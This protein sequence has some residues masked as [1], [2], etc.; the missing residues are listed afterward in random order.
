VKSSY[1]G[2]AAALQPLL[3]F[4]VGN[5]RSSVYFSPQHAYDFDPRY[6]APESRSA[7]R[8]AGYSFT[9][10]SG[11]G[12]DDVSGWLAPTLTAKFDCWALGKVALELVLG[13]GVAAGGLS[14]WEAQGWWSTL[15]AALVQV[16]RA[17]CADDPLQG[18]SVDQA[19]AMAFVKM[20]YP[21]AAADRLR[22]VSSDG[23]E[24]EEKGAGGGDGAGSSKAAMEA[25]STPILAARTAA[26]ASTSEGGDSVSLMSVGG[27]SSCDGAALEPPASAVAR[28][29]APAAAPYC[30]AFAYCLPAFHG[31]RLPEIMPVEP[32]AAPVVRASRMQPSAAGKKVAGVTSGS[33]SGGEKKMKGAKAVQGEEKAQGTKERSFWQRGLHRCCKQGRKFRSVLHEVFTPSSCFG[34]AALPV[35]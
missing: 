18:S 4:K 29:Q 17:L 7:A 8:A 26:A 13:G 34:G 33:V 31:P 10:A 11:T 3:A 25:P 32:A 19:L 20:D 27:G 9:P 12:E 14:E 21:V 15:P 6:L 5:L 23:E 22:V 24:E 16:V 2:A 35:V 30:C 1:G 28:Q